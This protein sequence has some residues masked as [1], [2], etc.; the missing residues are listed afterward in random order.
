MLI[1]PRCHKT[2]EE[3]EAGACMDRWVAE[4]MGWDLSTNEECWCYDGELLIDVCDWQPSTDPACSRMVW[5]KLK[6]DGWKLTI[7][8]DKK[9]E[10]WM[11]AVK[12]FTETSRSKLYDVKTTELDLAICRVALMTGESK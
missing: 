5:N 11:G 6:A 1:C 2:V 10:V 3:H 7:W 4:W 8:D 9:T 12:Y